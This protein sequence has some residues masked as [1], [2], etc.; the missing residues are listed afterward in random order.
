MITDIHRHY[1]PPVFFDFVKSRPEFQV[2]VKRGRVK[3]ST[4][5]FAERISV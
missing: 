3:A 5:K 1:V 2:R 4:L